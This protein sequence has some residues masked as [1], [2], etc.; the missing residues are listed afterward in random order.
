[1]L[2]RFS[3]VITALVLMFAIVGCSN[4]NTPTSNNAASDTSSGESQLFTSNKWVVNEITEDIPAPEFSVEPTKVSESTNMFEITYDHVPENEVVA[5]IEA[6]KNASFTDMATESKTNDRYL[7]TAQ[8]EG[9]GIHHSISVDY[10]ADGTLNISVFK[11]N[12]R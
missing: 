5:W 1:M 12:N 11:M 2:K 9:M 8:K 3:I 6:V 10:S 4:S 7:Y